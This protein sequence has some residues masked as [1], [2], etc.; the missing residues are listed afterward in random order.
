MTCF[1]L[2]FWCP[3]LL[4]YLETHR[5]FWEKHCGFLLL[6]KSKKAFGN[7]NINLLRDEVPEVEMK[8]DLEGNDGEPLKGFGITPPR[9]EP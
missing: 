7:Q 8:S 3:S 6:R 4:Y 2:V 5:L 9:G 1:D